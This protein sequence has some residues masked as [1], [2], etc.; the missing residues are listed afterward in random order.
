MLTTATCTTRPRAGLRALD[1]S[2]DNSGVPD[3]YMAALSC[4]TTLTQLT[5]LSV[6]VFKVRTVSTQRWPP[7]RSWR[8]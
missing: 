8:P 3:R 2:A 7:G 1:L 6:R 4:L 5:K